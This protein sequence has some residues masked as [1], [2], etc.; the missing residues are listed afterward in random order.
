MISLHCLHK[1]LA[2]IVERKNMQFTCSRV[3][4]LWFSASQQVFLEMALA[5]ER[6]LPKKDAG[7]AEQERWL[8]SIQGNSAAGSPPLKE[9]AK[10]SL[11]LSQSCRPL[12]GPLGKLGKKKEGH[13]LYAFK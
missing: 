9:Q 4:L 11:P 8:L 13:L 5:G 1:A 2:A 12:S 10:Q 3:F 6:M 7:T